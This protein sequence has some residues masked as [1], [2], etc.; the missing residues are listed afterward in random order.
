MDLIAA[1]LIGKELRGI[2]HTTGYDTSIKFENG[3]ITIWTEVKFN[4]TFGDGPVVVKDVAWS[5]EWFTI[6]FE[7]G[8]IRISRI[9]NSP[10]PEC[11][12]YGSAEDPD[13]AI[14]DRGEK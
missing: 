7:H 10:H 14:V 2:Q 8:D 12:I 3:G 5:N 4:V 9:P 6:L 11:F 13:L 1:R